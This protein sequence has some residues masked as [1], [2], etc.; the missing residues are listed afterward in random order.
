LHEVTDEKLAEEMGII[1]AGGLNGTPLAATADATFI[2]GDWTF[3]GDLPNPIHFGPGHAALNDG[4]PPQSTSNTYTPLRSVNI[5]GKDVLVNAFFVQWGD[6]S[7]ER[8]RID[9]NCDPNDPTSF[10]DDPPNTTCRYNGDNWGLDSAHSLEIN[11]TDPEPYV[12]MKLHKSWANNGDYLPYYVIA[13]SFP[14]GPANNM[15]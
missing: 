13:D 4:L 2:N 15:G 9:V 3:F 7:W 5:D 14:E 6:E 8:L 12:R 10:P 11:T 1:W